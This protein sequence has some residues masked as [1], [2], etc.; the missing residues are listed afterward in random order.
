[1]ADSLSKETKNGERQQKHMKPNSDNGT[2]GSVHRLCKE[3]A[4]RSIR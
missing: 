4:A 3:E 1:M 2:D